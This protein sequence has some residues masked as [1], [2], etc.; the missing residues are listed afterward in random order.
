MIILD[1]N[2]V[3]QRLLDLVKDLMV[4]RNNIQELQ[5]RVNDHQK[6]LFNY[7]LYLIKECISEVSKIGFELK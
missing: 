6:D 4:M 3:V 7:A 5:N 1:N 2:K